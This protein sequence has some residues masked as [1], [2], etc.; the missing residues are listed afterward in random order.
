MWFKREY[1]STWKKT[2]TI[3]FD[4]EGRKEGRHISYE[5]KWLVI[6]ETH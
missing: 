4:D 1:P 6:I 2:Y 3:H 5:S